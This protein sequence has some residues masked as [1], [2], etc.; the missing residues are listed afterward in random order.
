MGAYAREGASPWVV[1]D[2][3]ESRF[4]EADPWRSILEFESARPYA[5]S[6]VL[7]ANFIQYVNVYCIEHLLIKCTVIYRYYVLRIKDYN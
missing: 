7:Y 6:T 4:E 3:D 1:R 5:H 2:D